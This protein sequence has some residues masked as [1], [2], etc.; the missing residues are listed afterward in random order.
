MKPVKPVKPVN[1]SRN[2]P[3]RSARRRA[4]AA[5]TRGAVLP[6]LL[7]LPP[8]V[9]QA[10]YATHPAAQPF[11][12]EMVTEHGFERAQLEAWL[13]AAQKQQSILDAIAR[14][15]EK[16]KPWYEYRQIFLTERREREGA[17][18][19]R[20]H[21]NTLSRAQAETGVP[22]ELIVAIIGVET[23]Y[24][25]I[26][27]SYDVID[28]LA[29]LAFDYPK[30]SSFFSRELSEY[31]LLAREQGIDPLTPKG[32]YAGAM[33]YGQ[34]MPS[35][36]RA[37][38]V[39]FDGDGLADIWNNPVD[40]IG[41]VANYLA[42]HGWQA[43]EP[44]VSRATASGEPPPE[45]FAGGLKPQRPVAEFAAAGLTPVQHLDERAQAQAFRFELEDGHEYWLG[46]NNFY[47]ITRYNHSAMYAMSV[48]QLSQRIASGA[49]G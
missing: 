23:Y 19:L 48:Y 44:V 16:T 36:Y 10:D 32:S 43:G 18:F 40:A 9:A 49:S 37:Y 41:S 30:R 7:F 27:G 3:L 38:A 47:V 1:V 14:P 26:A 42:R 33:G 31:L 8:L 46:L 20:E 35:S 13:G 11:I 21:R 22:A 12:D 29:T 28:A 15:A 17:A 39:D 2:T 34:F 6:G 4:L 24:G 25:R 5:L 45:L